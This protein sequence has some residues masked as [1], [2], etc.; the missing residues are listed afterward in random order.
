MHKRYFILIYLSVHLCYL[1]AYQI[2]D[3]KT[4]AISELEKARIQ[5]RTAKKI[6]LSLPSPFKVVESR[7][8]ISVI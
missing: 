4:A 6:N 5:S 7:L 2:T 1:A 8:F 3:S